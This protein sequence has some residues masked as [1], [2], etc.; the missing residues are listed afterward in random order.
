MD[1]K[2]D[3]QQ[4]QQQ[5][6]ASASSAPQPAP[7]SVRLEPANTAVSGAVLAT[8]TAK[9][10]ANVD[11]NNFNFGAFQVPLLLSVCFSQ[12]FPLSNI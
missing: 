5:A 2:S 4:R 6:Q 3:V 9:E 11:L 10:Q 7:S 1:S 12:P 8:V